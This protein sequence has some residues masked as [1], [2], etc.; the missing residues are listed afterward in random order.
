MA[1]LYYG[2]LSIVAVT[3]TTAASGFPA[4]NIALESLGRPWKATGTGATD[5]VIDLGSSQA[6]NTLF[7][8]DVNFASAPI[9]RS[10]DNVSYTSVGTLTTYAGRHGR[11]RGK[12][13][14]GGA[15]AR[16]IRVS[17]PFPTPPTDGAAYWRIGSAYLFSSKVTPSAILTAPA[18]VSTLRPRVSASL[19]NGSTAVAET[20]MKI[21]RIQ[22][23]VDRDSA[24]SGDDLIQ[25]PDAGSVVL[26][27]ELSA[28][29]EQMWPIRYQ[30]NQL[31]ESF[32]KAMRSG[33]SM[34]FT[35]I[36]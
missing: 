21:D 4:S 24:Q 28:Y 13:S 17:M 19:A 18:Q 16:Y 23:Q 35:E 9:A 27:M 32:Q 10:T 3:T 14:F 2:K 12:I 34:S 15:S 25:L 1:S 20:G 31:S 29:P 6:I 8:H 5:V 30:E 26:D 11:R 7:L 33:W 36:T 22:V